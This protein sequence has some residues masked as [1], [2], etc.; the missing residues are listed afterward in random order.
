MLLEASGLDEHVHRPWL[1]LHPHG[2][3]DEFARPKARPVSHA[4]V[5][6]SDAMKEKSRA[7]A[8]C[9]SMMAAR[10]SAEAHGSAKSKNLNRW[11]AARVIHSR[12][13]RDDRCPTG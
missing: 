12:H 9:L 13:L 8:R 7:C 1:M 5:Y 10:A 2:V 4:V 11:H 3:L 6:V